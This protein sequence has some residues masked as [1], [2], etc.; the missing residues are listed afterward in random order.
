MTAPPPRPAAVQI[1]DPSTLSVA[2]NRSGRETEDKQKRLCRNVLVYG[3]CKYEN[4]GCPF[5]HPS[6]NTSNTNDSLSIANTSKSFTPS[7]KQSKSSTRTSEL[8]AE[9]LFAPV[10]VPKASKDVTSRFVALVIGKLG[11]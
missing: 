7:S 9:H 8:S 10:F 3:S 5:V 1:S 2:T 11:S 4:Q 6:S